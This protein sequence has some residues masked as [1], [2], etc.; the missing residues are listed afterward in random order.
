VDWET[1]ATMA[2]SSCD[3]SNHAR[4]ARHCSGVIGKH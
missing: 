4:A 1:C 3:K 2:R